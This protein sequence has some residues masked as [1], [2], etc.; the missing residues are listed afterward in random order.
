MERRKQVVV[1]CAVAAFVAS[2]QWAI[3]LVTQ[4]A[5]R[6]MLSPA[7]PNLFIRQTISRNFASLSNV[8]SSHRDIHSN[9]TSLR[10][11]TGSLRRWESQCRESIY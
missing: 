3:L 8:V 7:V 4:F 11:T 6:K 9:A 5:I 10:S 1:G 2:G